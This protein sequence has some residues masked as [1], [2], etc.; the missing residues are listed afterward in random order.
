MRISLGAFALGLAL[1]AQPAFE[2][3]TVK[4][5]PPPEGDLIN[6]NLG[7]VRNGK[8]TF[9]NASLSDCLKFA[10]DLASDAQLSGP[11]WIKSKQIR[12]DIVA[13]VPPGMEREQ[14]L[15]RLRTLLKE[16]LQVAVHHEPRN[17]PY[18]ALVVGK[19]GPKLHTAEPTRGG[20]TG[21]SMLG[22]IAGTQMPMRTLALLISRFERE[23]VIDMTGLGGVYQ[24]KLEWTPDLDR[25]PNADAPPG[26]SLF[27]AVQEQLGLKLESRKGPVDVLVVDHADQTPAEN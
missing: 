1:Q 13:Q 2:V 24:I 27:T 26:P 6:I 3:A 20:S 7:N 16:R 18:L 19:N 14:M 4:R 21:M 11:D 17:L 9:S 10:Y 22:H 23:T 8:L 25:P 12:F 5:S 15:M